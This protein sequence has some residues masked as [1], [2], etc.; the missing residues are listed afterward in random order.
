MQPRHH[1]V[2][3][4]EDV[5]NGGPLK[6]PPGGDPTWPPFSL[7]RIAFKEKRLTD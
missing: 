7:N 4:E 6:R 3:H 2:E 5:R 1:G